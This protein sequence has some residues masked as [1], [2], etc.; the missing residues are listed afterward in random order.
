MFNKYFFKKGDTKLEQC[1]KRQKKMT[2]ITGPVLHLKLHVIIFVWYHL[3]YYKFW[4]LEV[5]EVI[6]F[7][8]ILFSL[9]LDRM[10]QFFCRH[11]KLFFFYVIVSGIWSLSFV[12]VY[13]CR[14]CD[15]TQR[16]LIIPE[17][18]KFYGYRTRLIRIHT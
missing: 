15:D 10:L 8:F 13:C 14:K 3:I 5:L 6:I 16:F 18:P 9:I 17:E 2:K 11:L 4:M 7:T 1:L 12:Y